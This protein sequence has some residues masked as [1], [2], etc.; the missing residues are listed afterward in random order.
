EAVGGSRAAWGA[1]VVQEI[2]TGR[3]MAIAESDAVDPNNYQDSPP[4]N[5]GSRA[6][7][8]AYEPGSPGKLPT[9]AAAL[10]SGAVTPTTTFTSPDRYTTPSG[11]TFSDADPHPTEELTVAGILA[12][13]SNTGTV[14]IGDRMS[15]EERYA[16]FRA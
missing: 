1:L 10:D 11:Q 3:I 6:V 9:F 15:D 13:S 12:T 7:Q 5:R 4:E 16:Y 2:G 8:A 14:Q